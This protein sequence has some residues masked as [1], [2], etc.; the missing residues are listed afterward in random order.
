MSPKGHNAILYLYPDGV[1]CGRAVAHPIVRQLFA[2]LL[3][4]FLVGNAGSGNFN[5]VAHPTDALDLVYLFVG[6]H[7]VF[8]QGHGSGQRRD[9]VVVDAHL[10][11]L[12]LFLVELALDLAGDLVIVSWRGRTPAFAKEA[13]GRTRSTKARAAID[14]A[15]FVIWEQ[16]IML[17]IFAFLL[18]RA[19]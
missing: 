12:K 2:K 14:A 8:V 3:L 7:F 5:L 9:T 16:R 19:A 15:R 17:D 11:I 13:W 18:M 1:E 4:Q 6:V 10:H